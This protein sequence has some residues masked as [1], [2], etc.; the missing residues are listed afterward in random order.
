MTEISV[1]FITGLMF[2]IEFPDVSE[3]DED[4]SW[5]MALDLFVVRVMV[6]K[7]KKEAE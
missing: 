7:W 1:D 2:G 4:L 6:V 3:I 5:A